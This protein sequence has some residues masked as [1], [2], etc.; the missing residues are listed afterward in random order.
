MKPIG[1]E[2][3][4]KMFFGD[5]KEHMKIYSNDLHVPTW[6]IPGVRG[7]INATLMKFEAARLRIFLLTNC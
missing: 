3:D 1:L 4:E 6:G 2:I 5:F 7:K